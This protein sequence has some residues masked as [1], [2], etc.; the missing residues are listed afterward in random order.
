MKSKKQLKAMITELSQS[1]SKIIYGGYEKVVWEKEGNKE[2]W[3]NQLT[4]DFNVE[5]T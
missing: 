3:I 5:L 4:S 1:E 2:R